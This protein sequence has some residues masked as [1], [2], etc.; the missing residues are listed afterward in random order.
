MQLDYLDCAYGVLGLAIQTDTNQ[1]EWQ[2]YYVNK[3]LG[4]WLLG[5]A[6]ESESYRT[7]G[8]GSRNIPRYDA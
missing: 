2:T 3:P 8:C 7:E 5:S 6:S 4:D 1:C